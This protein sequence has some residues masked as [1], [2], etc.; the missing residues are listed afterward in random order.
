MPVIVLSARADA[1]SFFESLDIEAFLPKPCEGQVLLKHINQVLHK[2]AQ[3]DEP[4]HV[5][6]EMVLIAENDAIV[7]SMVKTALEND[8]FRTRV[9]RT[10]PEVLELAPKLKPDVIVLREYLPG[11]NGSVLASLLSAMSTTRTIPVV[12]YDD[13]GWI[14]KKMD[15]GEELKGVS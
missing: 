15:L 2:T 12:L 14:E 1:A 4:A 9:V 13:S 6:S 11:M 8:V 5:R 3:P 7:S 10:G